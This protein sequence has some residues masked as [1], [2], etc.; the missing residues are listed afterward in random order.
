MEDILGLILILIGII[1]LF[2]ILEIFAKNSKQSDNT[3]ECHS[4]NNTDESSTNNSLCNNNNITSLPDGF[5]DA[6]LYMND[7]PMLNYSINT[8]TE[9]KQESQKTTQ[10]HNQPIIKQTNTSQSIVTKTSQATTSH[11]CTRDNT[12]S[13]YTRDSDNEDKFCLPACARSF[14]A[15]NYYT[16]LS[17]RIRQFLQVNHSEKPWHITDLA[18]MLSVTPQ[19]ILDA[20]ALLKMQGE[21]Y[22]YINTSLSPTVATE[23][24]IETT[25]VIYKHTSPKGKVYIGQTKQVPERRWGTN[26]SNYKNNKAF[27]YDICKY[28]WDNFKHEIIVKNIATQTQCNYWEKY[29]IAKYHSNNPK[30]G[31]NKTSGGR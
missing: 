15:F 19:D 1:V 22:P 20:L 30:F 8:H 28:G 27:W 9:V 5:T 29:Y 7:L 17:H 2:I 31:Y 4:I 6:D 16:Q 14:D 18:N 12:I 26:G 23:Q 25:W 13:T 3:V 21:V 10:S 11:E 24:P